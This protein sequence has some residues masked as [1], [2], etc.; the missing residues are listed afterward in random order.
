MKEDSR[1]L[2]S[3]ATLLYLSQSLLVASLIGIGWWYPGTLTHCVLSWLGIIGILLIIRGKQPLKNLFFTGCFIQLFGFFWLL[4]TIHRFGAFPLVAAV[5]IF[6]VFVLGSA[7]QFPLFGLLLKYLPSRLNH[8]ALS[9]PIAWIISEQWSVRI[10][11]WHL[12]HSQLAFT[13]FAQ[14][15]GIVGTLGISFIMVWFA[16]GVIRLRVARKGLFYSFLV[17]IISVLYGHQQIAR[18]SAQRAERQTIS[19]ALIQG[20]IPLHRENTR[21]SAAN[22][23]RTH[24]NLSMPYDSE[25]TL[26][27]WPESAI[28]NWTYAGITHRSQDPRLPHLRFAPLLSGLLTFETREKQFNS[29]LLINS[30]GAIGTPYHKQILMPYGE[31][32]PLSQTF[33][34][35]MKINNMA[36]NFTA[37]ATPG[38]HRISLK[39]NG[40]EK[41][42]RAGTLICY[43]DV[44]QSLARESVKAG[45]E[46]LVNLTNDAWFGDTAALDQHHLIAS[47]RAI[48]NNRFHLRATNT[49]K[50]AIVNPLGTTIHE[51]SSATEGALK[52][53]IFPIQSETIYTRLGNLPWTVLSL[54][55]GLMVLSVLLKEKRAAKIE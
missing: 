37:G 46:F 28:M 41:T 55:G 5:P 47:F 12:G 21:S 13:E 54:L 2:F 52:G 4:E 50:T 14:I 48:E 7:L 20:N 22:D 1:R 32:T 23:I 40:V 24:L 27:I 16:E 38:I 9:A 33:P 35:L 51:L 36:A 44:I 45:A 49:G 11:P 8:Y 15:A 18:F 42:V 43:E 3:S 31:Y 17:M 25:N 6:I 39:D 19:V 10:F 29:A 53:E 34:W 30:D 26:I